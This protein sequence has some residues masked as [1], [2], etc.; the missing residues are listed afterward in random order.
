MVIASVENTSIVIIKLLGFLLI[1]RL[2]THCID[3]KEEL[4]MIISSADS[5]SIR[6]LLD[7]VTWMDLS[8][9]YFWFDVLRQRC[10][11]AYLANP[12]S[13]GEIWGQKTCDR[14]ICTYFSHLGSIMF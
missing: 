9:I 6:D 13:K 7:E 11:D 3:R 12:S 14:F 1:Q 8:I 4:D 2:S 10:K 5:K